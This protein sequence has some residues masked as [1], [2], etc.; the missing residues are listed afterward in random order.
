MFFFMSSTPKRRRISK[1]FERELARSEDYKINGD[2]EKALEIA[3]KVLQKDPGC[4]DAAEEVADNFLSLE[5]HEEAL[6]AAQFAYTLDKK[7]YI[8]NYVTGF[9]LLTDGQEDLA[10]GYLQVANEVEPNNPEILRCLGW[11]LFHLEQPISGVATLERAL[12]LRQDD[13]LI[14]C[15]LGVCLLQQGN[16]TKTTHLFE[17]ALSLDPENERA[18]GC[19]EAAINMEVQVRE[20]EAQGLKFSLEDLAA[21]QSFKV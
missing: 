14:L 11:T 18:K 21:L 15:D 1:K 17:K 16:F 8:A 10:L 19:L 9:L 6:K 20:M 12:N 13:A 5:M 7:S 2:F 4:V 3:Q